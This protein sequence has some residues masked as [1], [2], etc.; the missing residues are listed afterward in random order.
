[1]YPKQPVHCSFPAQA[2]EGG[3]V[4]LKLGHTVIGVD[5]MILKKGINFHPRLEAEHAS[6]LRRTQVTGT[7]ALNGD[8]FNGSAARTSRTR[9]KERLGNIVGKF[10]RDCHLEGF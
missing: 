1:L 5:T 9:W 7:I 3:L 10:N 6:N 4:T 8:R 2:K